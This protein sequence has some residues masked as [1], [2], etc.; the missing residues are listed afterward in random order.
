MVAVL[1]DVSDWLFIMYHIR[2]YTADI[3]LDFKGLFSCWNVADWMKNGL[4]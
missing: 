1:S 3:L 2:G 4:L